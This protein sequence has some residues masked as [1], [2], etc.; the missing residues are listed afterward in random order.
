MGDLDDLVVD[1]GAA[2][3]GDLY[4]VALLVAHDGLANGRL[5]A[6]AVVG[7][8]RLGRANDLIL[9]NVIGVDVTQ[10]DEAAQVNLVASLRHIDDRRMGED[11][12]DLD[13][14]ALNPSLLVLGVV[15]L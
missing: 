15:V 10:V 5:V 13:N 4:G 3:G 1:D 9:V 11:L 2:R 14:P 7:G 8:V 12:I 6:D